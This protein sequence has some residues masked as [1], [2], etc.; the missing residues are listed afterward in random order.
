MGIRFMSYVVDILNNVVDV[1]E[2][3]DYEDALHLMTKRYNLN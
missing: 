1:A 2:C 3:S